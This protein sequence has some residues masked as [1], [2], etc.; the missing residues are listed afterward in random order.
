[1]REVPRA[2]TSR[3]SPAHARLRQMPRARR[4]ARL[5]RRAGTV[6]ARSIPS[7]WFDSSTRTSDVAAERAHARRSRARG[8]CTPPRVAPLAHRRHAHPDRARARR[9]AS[10]YVV[11][12][13]RATASTLAPARHAHAVARPAAPASASH[14]ARRRVQ[15]PAPAPRARRRAL[16]VIGVLVRDD[17]RLDRLRRDADRRA[18]APRAC[19][20]RSPRRRA[21]G[22]RRDSISTALPPLPA[23]QHPELHVAT[24]HRAACA[25]RELR[26]R[27]RR[28]ARPAGA[29]SC[30]PP[31]SRNLSTRY[32]SNAPRLAPREWRDDLRRHRVPNTFAPAPSTHPVV[33]R[34][35]DAG[36]RVVAEQR[37]EE[38]QSRVAHAGRRPQLHGAVRVLQVARG[39]AGAEVHPAAEVRVADEA[40]VPLVRVAEKIVLLSS[41]CTLHVSP[42]DDAAM[43]S[44]G[45]DAVLADV[46]RA[47]EARE[48]LHVRRR[49]AGG[50]GPPSC[51]STTYGSTT[52]PS[53]D[54]HRVLADRRSRRRGSAARA[55]TLR[56]IGMS[57]VEHRHEVADEVPDLVHPPP[58]DRGRACRRA[59]AT[60]SVARAVA[61]R[62]ASAASREPH[63]G[64]A[65][66][67]RPARRRAGARRERTARTAR[68][69]ASCPA[70][71]R[72]RRAR[73]PRPAPRSRRGA[74]RR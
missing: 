68:S 32:V 21:R 61:Q 73:A 30:A 15:R 17:A 74:A 14:R 24:L 67:Q 55:S 69:R 49:A 56:A 51:R 65:S 22:S 48:R 13:H 35:A 27:S 44:V 31:T 9:A 62:R 63:R 20:C 72:R 19:A 43:R 4:D 50:S 29:P 45:D 25:A 53:L 37:A 11:T 7:S 41:P 54:A 16:H 39:R 46:A 47:D 38:L 59:R 2:R 28:R 58:V 6:R 10:A 3:T 40:V 52:A 57:A 33:S 1:M 23:A 26:A 8:R 5:H 12:L 60:S 34:S 66:V 42:I 36:L 70:G 64:D 71:T 18:A